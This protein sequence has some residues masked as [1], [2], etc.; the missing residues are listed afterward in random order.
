MRTTHR[1][2]HSD[3]RSLAALPDAS[4]DLVVTSPPY[5]MIE[6]WDEV[7]TRLNPEVGAALD[8]DDALGAFDLMHRELDRVWAECFRVLKAGGLACVNIGDATRTVAGEFALYSN[9]SRILQAML[10]NGFS[11]LPDILWRKPT[12]AP[13]KFLGSGMLPAGAYV[14]YEHEYVLILRKGSKRVFATDAAKFLRQES[15]FF[16]EERNVWFSDVWLELRGASQEIADPETRCRSAAFPF[17]LPYRLIQMHS[18]IGDT[19]LDPFAG[20]GTTTLAAMASGRSSIGVEVDPSLTNALE[21]A[22]RGVPRAGAEKV[23]ERLEAHEAFVR[24][25][26]GLGKPV[27]HRNRHYGFPVV[28]RQEVELRLQVPARVRSVEPLVW[29]V[30]YSE[31]ATRPERLRQGELPLGGAWK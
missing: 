4:V 11:S 1:I 30:Q 26:E 14:T 18:V 21:D 2:L 22:A 3:A 16:W 19:V 9:H 8:R 27:A 29:E 28:T 10:A 5:P 24:E 20:T 15:A 23:R 7:F 13:N 25:R 6:M 12:N 31:N 17:E